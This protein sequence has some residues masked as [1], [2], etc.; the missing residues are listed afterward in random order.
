MRLVCPRCGAQYEIDAAAIP[1]QGR[2]VECSSCDHVWRATRPFDPAARPTLSRPLNDSV[3]DILRQEAARELEARAAERAAE[4]AVERTTAALV[5][6]QRP[7]EGAAG[8]DAGANTSTAPP[9]SLTTAPAVPATVAHVQSLAP[10][11]TE[12]TDAKG[13]KDRRDASARGET[14]DTHAEGP[15]VRPA[16]SAPGETPVA[17]GTRPLVAPAARPLDDT[18]PGG[19]ARDDIP[20]RRIAAGTPPAPQAARAGRPARRRA[21]R[22]AGG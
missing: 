5:Q 11:G 6:F 19:L 8:P 18:L 13:P 14:A 9:S 4:R 16:L 12:D 7:R 3:L 10:A 17:P 21:V 1:P 22:R 20:P 2:D 15:E